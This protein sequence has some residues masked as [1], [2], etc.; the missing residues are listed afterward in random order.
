MDITLN[1]YDK[2]NYFQL[3][4]PKLL[5]IEQIFREQ[6]IKEGFVFKF[7]KT[8]FLDLFFKENQT[9]FENFNIDKSD[10]KLID[11]QY[12]KD[13]NSDN[14]YKA[15]IL[16]G[17]SYNSIKNENIKVLAEKIMIEQKI[18]DF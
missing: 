13:F 10:I 9:F 7:F 3:K 14:L 12:L 2:S 16:F 11:R 4:L 17:L 8:I 5:T 18:K 1:F 6:Y 15:A